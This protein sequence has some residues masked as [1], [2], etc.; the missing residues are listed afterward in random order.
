MKPVL[1]WGFVY[2][3]KLLWQMLEELLLIIINRE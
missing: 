3:E 1:K 2:I